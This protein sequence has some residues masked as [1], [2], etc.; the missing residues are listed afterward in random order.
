MKLIKYKTLI[1]VLIFNIC[2]YILIAQDNSTLSD[3]INR[4]DSLGYKHG[5]W[6]EYLSKNF[7]PV[8]KKEE[9][10]YYMYNLY[11]HGIDF[12]FPFDNVKYYVKDSLINKG[13][14]TVLDGTY[15]LYIKRRVLSTCDTSESYSISRQN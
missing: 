9:A 8:K 3:S 6:I 14:L 4:Y 11:C 1:I 7:H 15:K 12:F 13:K 10:S 5:Y 2:G